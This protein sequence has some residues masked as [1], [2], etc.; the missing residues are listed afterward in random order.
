MYHSISLIRLCAVQP[1]DSYLAAIRN[2]H[3]CF[4]L[5]V[6]LQL[7]TSWHVLVVIYM[8]QRVFSGKQWY[9]I[10]I[11]RLIISKVSKICMW[12]APKCVNR[13]NYHWSSLGLRT[14]QNDLN[15]EHFSIS[16][17]I[18][19]GNQNTLKNFATCFFSEGKP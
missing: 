6:K 17:F 10:Y 12:S 1:F 11:S 4:H 14:S 15:H 19:E 5:F 13:G 18:I 16:Y 8:L 7:P 9:H 2:V 3:I